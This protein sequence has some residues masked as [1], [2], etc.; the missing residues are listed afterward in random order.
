MGQLPAG[1]AKWQ[2]E[3]KGQ[4]AT[5]KPAKSSSK[6]PPAVY[7]NAPG[8]PKVGKRHAKVMTETKC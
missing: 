8:L 4:K 2:A 6:L 5:P 3:H 7:N 1:L